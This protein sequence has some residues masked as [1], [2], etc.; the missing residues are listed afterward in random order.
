M[1]FA[2]GDGAVVPGDAGVRDAA[3]S[4]VDSGARDDAASDAATGPAN[5]ASSDAGPLDAAVDGS[6]PFATYRIEVGAHAATILGGKPNNPIAGI[7][8]VGGR[9]FDLAFDLSARYEITNPVQPQDQLD[10]NKLPGFSDCVQ[11]DVAKA[12]A[13]FGWRWRLDKTPRIL[14]VT[15]YANVDGVHSAKVPPMLELSEAELALEAPLRYRVIIDGALYRFAIDGSIGG[16]AIAAQ[17]T[18][19]RGC[20][21]TSATFLK[22]TS[23]LYFG[24]TSTAPSVITARVFERPL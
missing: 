20:P 6:V 24:G 9:D 18:L 14:E 22:W 8:S 19:T 7:A 1:C 5:D 12:G 15:A 3:S 4:P 11:L 23:G 2:C 21:N 17:T 10:W 13:M 16:R